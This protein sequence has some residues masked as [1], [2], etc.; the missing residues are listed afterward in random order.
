MW[1]IGLFISIFPYLGK[2][3]SSHTTDLLSF[4]N[5]VLVLGPLDGVGLGTLASKN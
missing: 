3:L 5:V 2:R 4:E 1:F